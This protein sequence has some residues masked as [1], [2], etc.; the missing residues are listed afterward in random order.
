[1]RFFSQRPT[2]IVVVFMRLASSSWVQRFS[3]RSCLMVS[4]IVFFVSSNALRATVELLF[5]LIPEKGERCSRCILLAM[6]LPEPASESTGKREERSSLLPSNQ[7]ISCSREAYSQMR[8]ASPFWR[9]ADKGRHTAIRSFL[10]ADDGVEDVVSS[11]P[12]A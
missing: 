5:S 7:S 10:Q 1:V 6:S 8:P 9:L 11:S 4:P 3:W 2:L 12:F